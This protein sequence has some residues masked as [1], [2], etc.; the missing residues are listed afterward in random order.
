MATFTDLTLVA[1]VS[2]DARFRNICTF[3]DVGLRTTSGWTKTTCTG[4][5]DPTTIAHPT[6]ANTKQGFRVY[7]MADS[8][9]ATAPIYMRVDWG[10]GGAAATF[11]M[12]VTLGTG[13]NTGTGAITGV[14]FGPI[15]FGGNTNSTGA[16]KSY[17]SGST[18]RFCI[19][20]FTTTSNV[21]WMCFGVERTKNSNGVD[22]SDGLLILG[23]S[24]TGGGGVADFS[25]YANFVSLGS[26][27]AQETAWTYVL[28]HVNPSTFSSN[29]GVSLVIQFAGAAVQPGMN[30]IVTRSSDFAAGATVTVTVYGA[31]RTYQHLD[32]CAQAKANAGSSVPGDTAGRICI[33]YD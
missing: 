2:T 17:G 30:F 32:V 18:N 29:V 5:A 24:T 19:A 12:W 26:Q 23:Q 33:R 6:V 10:S 14:A 3:I 31:S 13:V 28:S 20:L 16:V 21:G 7:A 25:Q 1:D 9:Q 15:Q 11:A 22:T 4:E 8:L 27:P